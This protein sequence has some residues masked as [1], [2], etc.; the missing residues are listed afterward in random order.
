MKK[1]EVSCDLLNK[2]KP[3]S[4]NANYLQDCEEKNMLKTKEL[5]QVFPRM[6]ND[7]EITGRS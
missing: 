4:Q 6:S 3:S 7:N 2:Q 5:M 1:K